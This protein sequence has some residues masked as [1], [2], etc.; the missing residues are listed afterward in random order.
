MISFR[1]WLVLASMGVGSIAPQ[2]LPAQEIKPGAKLKT[3]PPPEITSS[4]IRGRANR[5]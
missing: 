3:A 4:S 5:D 1:R 2:P